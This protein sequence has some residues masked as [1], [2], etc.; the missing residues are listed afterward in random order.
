MNHDDVWNFEDLSGSTAGHGSILCGYRAVDKFRTSV[1]CD[2]LEESNG[3]GHGSLKRHGS[4]WRS[5]IWTF[6]GTFCIW[7][8]EK[9]GIKGHQ[10]FMT[11]YWIFVS[12][13]LGEF[14]RTESSPHKP[15]F[16]RFVIHLCCSVSESVYIGHHQDPKTP[17]ISP[18]NKSSP[19]TT[20]TTPLSFSS[21]IPRKQPPTESTNSNLTDA[22]LWKRVS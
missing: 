13:A 9:S 2:T 15:T 4:H 12:G 11:P 7:T 6:S 14:V 1:N 22:F 8:P 10:G 5:G 3:M 17:S 19:P 18:K 21:F 20:S 16:T